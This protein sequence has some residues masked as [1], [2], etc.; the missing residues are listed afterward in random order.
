VN[1][2]IDV[3]PSS[4]RFTTTTP[5]I[6]SRHAFSYGQHYDPDNTSFGLLL[7]HND[8]L[9]QPG[10][11][12]P[13]H[14]HRDVDIVSWV[15]SGA[16]R[17]ADDLGSVEIVAAGTA[18]CLN[19]GSGVRHAETNAADG[20][21]RYV[22][23]WLAPSEDGKPAYGTKTIAG[24]GFVPLASGLDQPGLL[25][26]R[27][28]ATFGVARLAVDEVADLEGAPF[29]HLTA[30]RGA[31]S[32]SVADADPIPLADG[33]T[34]RITGSGAVRIRA[35]EDAEVLAWVMDVSVESLRR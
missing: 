13:E 29:V 23:I 30:V 31:V 10:A 25:R 15:V 2:L 4:D 1:E 17:H 28:P 22:Q 5:G 11:G 3:R 33:D 8:D 21:T 19:A 27:A 7:A 32:L 18:Q 34:A 14:S 6:T 20:V 12:Y 9:L 26:L 24:G 16:L 35:V